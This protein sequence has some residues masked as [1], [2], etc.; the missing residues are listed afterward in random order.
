M[1]VSPK[2][3]NNNNLNLRIDENEP[4]SNPTPPVSIQSGKFLPRTLSA[5][6]RDLAADR[7]VDMNEQAVV[8]D[9]AFGVLKQTDVITLKMDAFGVS[10]TLQGLL[11]CIQER[12]KERIKR[13]NPKSTLYLT[14][15]CRSQVF[16]ISDKSSASAY[17]FLRPFG[18]L[19]SA[20]I[21]T[22]DPRHIIINFKQHRLTV[23][24][25][26]QNAAEGAQ[27][28]KAINGIKKKEQID[29]AVNGYEESN[30]D[31]AQI[32]ADIMFKG[33][34]LKKGK[35]THSE[36]FVVVNRTSINVYHSLE[37]FESG[38]PAVNRC[39][40][41]GVSIS[42]VG[43]KTVWLETPD[44]EFE[45]RLETKNEREIF[46][47]I[48][49]EAGGTKD[50]DYEETTGSVRVKKKV[51]HKKSQADE[52]SEFALSGSISS[53]KLRSNIY[54]L[55]KIL[56]KC[57]EEGCNLTP[58]VFVPK[59]VW[60]Q[61]DLKLSALSVK[62]AAFTQLLE[63]LEMI[64]SESEDGEKFLKNLIDLTEAI[65]PI[66]NSLAQHL[67]YVH[68][69]KKQVIVPVCIFLILFLFNDNYLC[70][71]RKLKLVNLG[72]K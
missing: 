20:K 2:K 68:E 60:F 8:E 37:E 56:R 13:G 52:N 29:F 63:K 72:A 7:M 21:S 11:E 12:E 23:D 71:I 45:F 6:S 46:F 31:A 30:M 35:L 22:V 64:R 10:S 53:T 9:A 33:F 39:T 42:R 28:S 41:L 18:A 51:G 26:S 36:R 67:S 62:N 17:E 15:D 25:Y 49:Q 48:L 65:V 24:V 19:V 70:K 40:L 54:S 69:I 27:I 38:A 57:M 3:I 14:L 44:R 59:H 32:A 16:K 4:A 50:D 61:K 43:E 66:Q 1:P 58:K 55:M 5:S 47:G 34:M